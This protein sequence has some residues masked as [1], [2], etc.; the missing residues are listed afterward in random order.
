M[1]PKIGND[2]WC[3]TK[4]N[5]PKLEKRHRLL[6]FRYSSGES[7]PRGGIFIQSMC[8]GVDERDRLQKVGRA[9]CVTVGGRMRTEFVV[10]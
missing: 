8:S 1:L 9:R 10:E 5:L 3:P 4:G 7:F 2:A 6:R